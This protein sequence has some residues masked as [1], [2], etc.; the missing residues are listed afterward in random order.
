MFRHLISFQNCSFW[1]CGFNVVHSTQ[2]FSLFYV[3]GLDQHMFWS[4]QHIFHIFVEFFHF[5]RSLADSRLGLYEIRR[6][7]KFCLKDIY[8][9]TVLYYY[10]IILCWLRLFIFF[11]CGHVITF[12]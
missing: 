4:V 11:N 5:L 1:N 2:C 12:L 10:M 7:V 6:F 9:N 8:V 3:F